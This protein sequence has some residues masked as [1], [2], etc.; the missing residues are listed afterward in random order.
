MRPNRPLELVVFDLDFTVWQPEMYQL[1]G[2]PKLTG[3]MNSLPG[4]ARKEARTSKEGMILVDKSGTPIRVFP[5]AYVSTLRL[6]L[7][8]S[9]MRGCLSYTW[10]YSFRFTLLHIIFKPCQL[11]C[12]SR[13]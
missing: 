13:Y 9:R 12:I 7:I 4:N 1:C 5:G 10:L 11:L 3:N 8:A 2:E 6:N